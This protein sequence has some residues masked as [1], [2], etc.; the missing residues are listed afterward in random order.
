MRLS[1]AFLS[2]ALPVAAFS[3]A[4]AIGAEPPEGVWRGE[5][6]IPSTPLAVEIELNRG[7]DGTLAGTIDIPQQNAKDLPLEKIVWK[8]PEITFAIANTPGQPTFTG[9]FNETSGTITGGF[10]QGGMLFPFAL[11]SA[12]ASTATVLARLEDLEPACAK[13]LEEFLV[14]GIAIAI[15]QNG[16]TIYAKGF[17]YRDVENKVPMTEDTLLAIGSASKAFTTWVLATLVEEGK[18]E[19][20]KPVVDYL[21]EFRLSNEYATQH[22]TVR[23]LVTHRSGL[24]RHDLLWYG[25]DTSTRA[26]MVHRLRYL[27]FSAEPREIFQYNNLMYLTAGY[28][29]ERVGGG[30]WEELVRKRIFEPLGMKRSVFSPGHMAKDDN[31]ALCYGEEEDHKSVKKLPYRDFP[32]VGPAGSINASV[33]E[34]AEWV[35]LQLGKGTIGGKELLPKAAAEELHRGVEV[36]SG[37]MPERPEFQ[38]MQYALGWMVDGYRGHHRIHHGGNID[39][40]SALVTFFPRDNAGVVVLVNKAGSG[41][42]E[43]LSR[44]VADRLFEL[45]PIDWLSEASANRAQMIAMTAGAAEKK[46]EVSR[47]PDTK[48][49]LALDRYVATYRDKGYGDIVIG[50]DEGTTLTFQYRKIK[51]PM[52]HWHFDT[53]RVVDAGPESVFTDTQVQFQL[54][55]NGDVESFRVMLEPAVDP[56][57]FK[58]IADESFTAPE[59]LERFSGRYQL[60]PQIATI[61]RKGKAL[62]V[63][64]PGQPTYELLPHRE[65][66]FH[67]AELKGYRLLFLLGEDGKPHTARFDQ[68]N[69]VFDMKK[70]EE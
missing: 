37:T 64:L 25:D 58:R 23:D 61:S 60:G 35:K 1:P 33:V 45:A 9:T 52:E 70:L 14:P 2:C 62:S 12:A 39:G 21:P 11:E 15:V 53:F 28:L 17:G 67:F 40:F 24:P 65:N 32:A 69:G 49:S 57:V 56:I 13:L 36:M 34:M 26:E 27:P 51:E 18:L 66:E 4:T 22:L 19:W 5:I 20:D 68:P 7:K 31:Y 30:T 3:L 55:L 59:Y 50:L 47:V 48:P 16:E 41:A 42:P 63:A 54:S 38:P 6:K 10:A 29:A 46:Q 44:M 43:L 8:A